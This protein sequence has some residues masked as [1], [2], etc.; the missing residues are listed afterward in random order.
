MRRALFIAVFA[1]FMDGAF[2]GERCFTDVQLRDMLSRGMAPTEIDTTV[3]RKSLDY[4]RCV[5]T[6]AWLVDLTQP[7]WPYRSKVDAG[8]GM[9][10]VW[11]RGSVMVVTCSD[12]DNQMIVRTSSYGTGLVAQLLPAPAPPTQRTNTTPGMR[13][14][15]EELQRLIATI[16]PN[17]DAAKPK[18]QG[19]PSFSACVKALD[20]SA[21]IFRDM[22][23]AYVTLA[24]KTNVRADRV[25]M[26]EGFGYFSCYGR[27]S[28]DAR[29]NNVYID[30]AGKTQ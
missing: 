21:K 19:T 24:D 25:L 1:I 18:Q 29:G 3:D 14:S 13:Y 15:G 11:H 8:F 27:D 16:K 17:P 6:A 22:G 7:A 20:A 4:K 5:E 30:E 2:A 9:W 26:A 12:T 10:K 23:L 28:V